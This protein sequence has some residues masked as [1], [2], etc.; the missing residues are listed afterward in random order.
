MR[1]LD[2]AIGFAP[3]LVSLVLD[4]SK[5][6]TY[7]LGDTWNFL[8]PGDSILTE[9]SS[10]HEVFAELEITL[11]E[12]CTFESLPNNADGHEIYESTEKRR[13]TFERY[14]G[15][16]VADSEPVIVIGFKVIKTSSP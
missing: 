7:R 11:K 13:V 5:T 2:K 10:S 12:I 6:L 1:Y 8:N 14:Y 9:D 16:E 4:G 15:R 3:E